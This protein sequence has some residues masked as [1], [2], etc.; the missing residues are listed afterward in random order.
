M[1]DARDLRSR[2]RIRLELT[3]R[4][5]Q[6]APPRNLVEVA[7]TLDVS[8]NGI[9]F[10]TRSPYDANSTVWITMPYTEGATHSDPEFPA[11]VIRVLSVPDG[12]SEIAVQ[13]FSAHADRYRSFYDGDPAPLSA[14]ARQRRTRVKMTLPI[15]V[16][17]GSHSEESVTMNISR[18][19]VL[20]RTSRP[21]NIGDAVMV[22]M[23]YQPG[24]ES[25]EVAAVV[26]RVV[27]RLGVRGVA[28]QF[29]SARSTGSSDTWEP[30]T[31]NYAHEARRS[32][33]F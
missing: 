1:S 5:R 29:A 30:T 22:C 12:N 7:R 9:L 19:G 23:P 2:T 13:F 6:I 24:A 26:I 32:A 17:R 16:R 15:R 20:F 25:S 3:A 10:R 8:R 21:Y 28:L 4:I 18:S 27:E 11:S 33:A 31:G 14:A